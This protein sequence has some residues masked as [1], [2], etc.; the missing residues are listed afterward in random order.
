MFLDFIHVIFFRP[1][2]IVAGFNAIC[3]AYLAG[4]P[5]GSLKMCPLNL[6]LF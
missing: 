5:T 4:V 3:N 1:L 2:G 6:S